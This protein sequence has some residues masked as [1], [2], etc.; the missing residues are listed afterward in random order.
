VRSQ[1]LLALP[2][3]IAVVLP[4]I[5]FEV[6]LVLNLEHARF[7]TYGVIFAPLFAMTTLLTVLWMGLRI[8]DSCRR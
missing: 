3:T 4:V 1:C 2:V 6:L 7:D 5:V 8:W